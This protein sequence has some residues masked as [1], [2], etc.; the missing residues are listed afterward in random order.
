M[1]RLP[2]VQGARRH[3]A[4]VV[5]RRAA[6]SVARYALLGVQLTAI[7]TSGVG[8]LLF[9]GAWLAHEASDACLDALDKTSKE[10]PCPS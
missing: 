3:A 7:I 4:G 8:S 1:D 2:V 9:I 6:V 10:V 5:I